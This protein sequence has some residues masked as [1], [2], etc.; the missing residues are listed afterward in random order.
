MGMIYKLECADGH[1]YYGSTKGSLETRFALHKKDSNTKCSPVY[2]HINAIGWETV[3]IVLV[4]EIGD[5]LKKRED[6]YIRSNIDDP[7]CLNANIVIA[8]GDDTKKWQR[9]Y[10]NTHKEHEKERVAAW[11]KANPE[12]TA[13]RQRKYVEKDPEQYKANQ[14][15]WYERNRARILAQQKAYRDVN[16]DKTRAYAKT[17][18][19]TVVAKKS[20][21]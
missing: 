13:A 1:Y 11:Q 16:R 12:K 17:Y 10:R 9:A 19:A 20:T 7:L 2:T 21:T 15:A 14:K 8:T 18:Y 4:E 5:G 6:D 3:R